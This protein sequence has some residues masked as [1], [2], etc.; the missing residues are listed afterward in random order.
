MR[1][2]IRQ[3]TCATVKLALLPLLICLVFVDLVACPGLLQAANS[4]REESDEQFLG[5]AGLVVDET[6]TVVGRN[7]FEAL[8]AKWSSLSSSAQNVVVGELAD[9]RFGSMIS[10]RVADRIIFRRL[11]PPRLD[12]VETVVEM[13]IAKLRQTLTEQERV[14]Q[15][16]DMY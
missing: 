5:I 16:L 4:F 8:S 15:E 3:R 2:I 11:L 14:Q 6:R 1:V 9:P 13:A 12:E 7:F 10:I